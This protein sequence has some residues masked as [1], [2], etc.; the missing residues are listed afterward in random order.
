MQSISP[1]L[2]KVRCCRSRLIHSASTRDQLA[3]PAELCVP[4]LP[5]HH[6]GATREAGA[7]CFS[8]GLL[9]TKAA[10][11][12]LPEW[13][14]VAGADRVSLEVTCSLQPRAWFFCGHLGHLTCH[15]SAPVPSKKQQ[16][17]VCCLGD[18]EGLYVEYLVEKVH[19]LALVDTRSPIT[20][21]R[22]GVQRN[23]HC[24]KGK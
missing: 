12:C 2:S 21:I 5:T 24:S 8:L 1:W 9:A 19:C 14:M 17:R 7:P 11:A 15:C 13:T 22:P 4:S 3:R 18:T 20:L 10:T 16:K 23:T 6:S